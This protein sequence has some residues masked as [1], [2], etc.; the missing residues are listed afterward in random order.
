MEKKKK[1]FIIFLVLLLMMGS[2]LPVFADIWDGSSLP[3]KPGG[4]SGTATP[5]DGKD[6]IPYMSNK[7]ICGYRFSFYDGT[8]TKLGNSIDIGIRN[9]AQTTGNFYFSQPPKAI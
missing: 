9:P 5:P 8:G 3:I 7:T 1:V 4:S 2:I 6:T